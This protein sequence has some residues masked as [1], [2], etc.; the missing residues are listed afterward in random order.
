[1]YLDDTDTPLQH[2]RTRYLNFYQW[3]LSDSLNRLLHKGKTTY[4]LYFINNLAQAQGL[5]CCTNNGNQNILLPYAPWAQQLQ[6]LFNN[7]VFWM[8]FLCASSLQIS[9]VM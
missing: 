1:L 8:I 5:I 9:G 3:G 2:L 6:Q 4:L 7:E